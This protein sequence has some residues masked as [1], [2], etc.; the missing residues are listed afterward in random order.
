MARQW[1]VGAESKPRCEPPSR[2][3]HEPV[4][5]PESVVPRD[6]LT[7]FVLSVN[8]GDPDGSQSQY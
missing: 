1:R 6:H 3:R 7:P 8:S 4:L 2:S 5:L